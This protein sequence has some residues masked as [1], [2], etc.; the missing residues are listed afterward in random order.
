M[1]KITKILVV[2]DDEAVRNL[3]ERCLV[4]SGFEVIKIDRGEGVA[5]IVK[6]QKIDLVVL[7]LILP[8]TDGLALTRKL[9]EHSDVGVIILSG[10]GDTTEKVIGLEIGADDYLA[11]PFE[12][13]ELLARLRSVLR[14]IGPK[15]DN[16]A[17]EFSGLEFDG[18]KL[19]TSAQKLES[20]DGEAIEISSGEFTLLQVLVEHPNRVLSR[21]QLLE[22]THRNYTPAFDRSVDVQIMR[23][24]KKIE[25]NP[26]TPVIIK[27]VRNAGYIFTPKVRQL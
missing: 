8:D 7:D 9:K 6:E 13:R 23:L 15:A 22:F 14:R 21:E 24:R 4:D 1:D 26:Q 25:D 27:T 19:D 11:K 16:H 5:E 18:W 2:D 17:D 12:P 10:R 20:P 3:V